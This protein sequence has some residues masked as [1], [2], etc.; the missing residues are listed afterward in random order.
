MSNSPFGALPALM[1]EMAE[2][3]A[4]AT[5]DHQLAVRSIFNIMKA[6]GG[7]IVYIR[8]AMT[9]NEWLV[10]AVGL[11]VATILVPVYA[12]KEYYTIPMGP[13]GTYNNQAYARRRIIEAGLAN[14]LT[15]N[16]VA[17]QAQVTRRF[18]FWIKAKLTKGQ[19]NA[20]QLNLFDDAAA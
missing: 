13:T 1:A 17:E 2:L 6:K 18:V 4:D 5:G 7:Q 20:R 11:D 9:A 19:G 3:I 12:S 15:V 10:Q 8:K 16:E 14:G